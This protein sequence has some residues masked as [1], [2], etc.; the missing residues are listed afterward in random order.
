[1]QG[2]GKAILIYANDFEDEFPRAGGRQSPW[3][4]R[5]PDWKA[6]DRYTAYGVTPG[7]GEGGGGSISASLYLLVKYAEELPKSFVCTGEKKQT[8]EFDLARVRGLPR[9]FELID[10]WDFGPDPPKHVSYAYHMVYGSE[11]LSNGS[12]PGMAI[13]SER[14][15]WM[16]S[17]FAR[18]RDFARF[19]PDIAP[20]NGTTEAALKGNALAHHGDGQNVL[21]VDSHVEFSKR[22]FCGID[23]DN[24]YTSWDGADKVRGLAATFGS[25]PAGANDSLLVNDPAVAK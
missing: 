13:L 16:A 4:A 9:G 1:M 18:A 5:I 8:T 23:D 11:K 15:P 7:T 17:P 20:F 25:V 10:A 21:F 14:N 19:Q 24:I 2:I 6:S 3:A 12:E 22:A